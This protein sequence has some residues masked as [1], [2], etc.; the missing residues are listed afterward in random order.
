MPPCVRLLLMCVICPV[1]QANVPFLVIFVRSSNFGWDRLPDSAASSLALFSYFDALFLL[2]VWFWGVNNDLAPA[3]VCPALPVHRRVAAFGAFL[4]DYW[5]EK[6]FLWS[7]HPR[8]DLCPLAMPSYQVGHF[9]YATSV[10]PAK[11]VMVFF[12]PSQH[13][14]FRVPIS[15]FLSIPSLIYCF[16][17]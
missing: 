9:P 13:V 7:L 3:C 10:N 17:V 16:C 6:I 1:N 4:V 12:I 2:V 14:I 8:S 15:K 11:S 5:R